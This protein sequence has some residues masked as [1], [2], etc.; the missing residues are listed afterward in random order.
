MSDLNSR[1]IGAHILILMIYSTTALLAYWAIIYTFENQLYHS[2]LFWIVSIPCLLMGWYWAELSTYFGE[3]KK[4][5]WV[6]A[7]SILCFSYLAIS[8]DFPILSNSVYLISFSPFMAM[9]KFYYLEYNERKNR[10]TI[11]S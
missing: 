5:G 10:R 6:F 9:N 3:N 4:I 1:Q 8:G 7:L 2:L 11:F